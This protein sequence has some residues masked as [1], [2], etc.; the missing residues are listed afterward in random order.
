MNDTGLNP[1]KFE[2]AYHKKGS[3]IPMNRDFP[4]E[5]FFSS[6]I[7]NSCNCMQQFVF[8]KKSVQSQKILFPVKEK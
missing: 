8:L 5:F 2:S 4:D 3:T 1:A 6:F 7:K